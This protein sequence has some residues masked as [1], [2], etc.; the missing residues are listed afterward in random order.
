MDNQYYDERR[1]RREEG[2]SG[3]I[4]ADCFLFIPSVGPIIEVVVIR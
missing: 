4:Q 2:S 3:G 1:G